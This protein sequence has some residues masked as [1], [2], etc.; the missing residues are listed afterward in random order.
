MDEDEIEEILQAMRCGRRAIE[1]GLDGVEL[2][3]I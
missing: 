2:H 1:A 3:L